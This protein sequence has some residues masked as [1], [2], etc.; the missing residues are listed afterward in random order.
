MTLSAKLRK[1]EGKD[2]EGIAHWCPGCESLHVI[3]TRNPPGKPTWSWNG[4]V[5][6][7]TCA[8]SVLC[9]TTGDGGKR[10]TLCHY[11]LRAGKIEFCGDCPHALS[12]KTVDLPD[13]PTAAGG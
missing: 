11:F 12:G 10:T 1:V 7:P 2:C 13:L 3:W 8:P 9:F 4:D 6:N 5:N